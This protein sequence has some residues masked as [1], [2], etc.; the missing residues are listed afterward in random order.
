[1][2]P[3]ETQQ[4]STRLQCH[5]WLAT[6]IVLSKNTQY[7][8]KSGPQKFETTE[9]GVPTFEVL[10]CRQGFAEIKNL[11][12]GQVFGRDLSLQMMPILPN[13]CEVGP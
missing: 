8:G 11:R 13:T 3:Q 4:D 2:D 5:W 7:V 6:Y 10:Q 9:Q 12:T 1:M